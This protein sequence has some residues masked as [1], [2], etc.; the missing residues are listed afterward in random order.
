[1]K[2]LAEDGGTRS[3][4]IGLFYNYSIVLILILICAVMSL[5][6]SSFY[7][8]GNLMNIVRQV[9]VVGLIA[10]GMTFVI[11]SGGIDLSAGAV[12][13]FVGVIVASMSKAGLPLVVVIPAGIAL[14]AMCGL[15]SGVAISWLSIPPFI[16]TLGLQQ[17]ARAL[18]LIYS[19]GRPIS[20]FTDSFLFIGRGRICMIPVPIIIFILVGIICWFFLK[21]NKFGKHVYAIGGN[22]LASVVCGIKVRR[23]KTIIYVIMGALTGLAAIVLTSRVSTGN[24]S[25]GSGYELD[26][27]TGVVIGGASLSG[28]SGSIFGTVIGALIIGV[29]SNGLSL[30]G[31]SPYWQQFINGSLIISAVALDM[32][33]NKYA[34]R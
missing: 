19:K 22:E 33:K 8:L 17:I 4:T 20:N 18:A 7:S 2:E 30:L 32:F 29:L 24:P 1:M 21:K 23:V 11:I 9:A 31:V 6:T 14:G 34:N 27:I 25:V 12:V 16:A 3:K 5:L 28:G 13:A 10:Y 26:A 15:V